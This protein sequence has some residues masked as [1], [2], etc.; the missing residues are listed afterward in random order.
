VT[1]TQDEMRWLGLSW[2]LAAR[3]RSPG[4]AGRICLTQHAADTV[5]G[6]PP[7]LPRARMDPA[8]QYHP[9]R[10]TGLSGA[11]VEAPA[12]RLR[13]ARGM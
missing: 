10:R 1:L 6:L 5:P 3:V 8:C 2:E 12:G 9:C 13:R 4:R 7:D 11:D